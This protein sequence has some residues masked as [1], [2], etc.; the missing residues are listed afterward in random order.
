MDGGVELVGG[1]VE[2]SSALEVVEIHLDSKETRKVQKAYLRD[3]RNAG[4]L[5]KG[6]GK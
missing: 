3:W 2:D 5:R 1:E 6:K 4:K